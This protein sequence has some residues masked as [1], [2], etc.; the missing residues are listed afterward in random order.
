MR[1][2]R[3]LA[4]ASV[5]VVAVW[6]LFCHYRYDETSLCASCGASELRSHWYVGVMPLGIPVLHDFGS[7]HGPG[8][9]RISSLA[10][11]AVP[12]PAT[13]HLFPPTHLHSWSFAGA[14]PSDLFGTFP[15]GCVTGG[16][17]G[18]SS[19]FSFLYL[20]DPAFVTYVESLIRDATLTRATALSLFAGG[21]S[22]SFLATDRLLEEYWR[23][24][25]HPDRQRAYRAIY[26]PRA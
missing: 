7:A 26:H 4:P 9:I 17:R 5:V 14:T 24:H 23:L 15:G 21:T 1:F 3:R 16:G 6:L 12:S 18:P 11:R 19:P 20:Q 2:A 8:A 10:A 13:L 25:P 22:E